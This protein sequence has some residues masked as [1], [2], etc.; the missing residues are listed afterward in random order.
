MKK[1][2]AVH[3]HHVIYPSKEHPEQEL[4]YYVYA[5]EHELLGKANLYSRKTISRGF[6]ESLRFFILRNES[7][8]VDLGAL[9]KKEGT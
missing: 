4:V 7:R 3:G 1:P 2:R 9:A 6:L 5:G 8:A